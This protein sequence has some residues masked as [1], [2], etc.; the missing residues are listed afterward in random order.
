ML[1][2]DISFVKISQPVSKFLAGTI[3]KLIFSISNNSI[4]DVELWFLFSAHRLM[5]LYIST[6]NMKIP[7]RV[8]IL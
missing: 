4:K 6:K 3:S 8:S 2:N 1:L 5:E 7:Q